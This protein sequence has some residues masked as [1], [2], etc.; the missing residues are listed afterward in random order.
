MNMSEVFNDTLLRNVLAI[1]FAVLILWFLMFLWHAVMEMTG[2][3][4]A[5]F[6]NYPFNRRTPWTMT[7][8]SPGEFLSDQV[9]FGNTAQYMVPSGLS[10]YLVNGDKQPT[11][12][13]Q[14]LANQVSADKVGF[15]PSA[16]D[17]NQFL[18]ASSKGEIT[19]LDENSLVR[20]LHGDA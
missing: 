20:S 15:S 2:M 6:S 8:G 11:P 14:D 9:N 17:G 4:K 13:L 10:P 3:G 16:K 1:V 12:L 18:G 5:G 7:S 19:K